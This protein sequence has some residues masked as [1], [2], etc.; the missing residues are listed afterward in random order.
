M[1]IK[2]TAKDVGRFVETREGQVATISIVRKEENDPLP[3]RVVGVSEN[4]IR[5]V[6]RDGYWISGEKHSYDI[7]AF[8][9]E[10]KRRGR[11]RKVDSQYQKVTV[12]DIKRMRLDPDPYDTP[13][14]D[15][16]MGNNPKPA[17]AKAAEGKTLRDELETLTL[18]LMDADGNMIVGCHVYRF[19]GQAVDTLSLDSGYDMIKTMAAREGK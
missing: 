17:Q 3:V 5:W 11:P 9:D 18:K 8:A 4:F 1:T 12:E 2:I 15:V 16:V 13:F 14:M 6:T 7:I 10:P 19:K